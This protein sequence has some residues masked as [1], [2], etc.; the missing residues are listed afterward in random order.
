[1][2]FFIF[3]S[4]SSLSNELHKVS[5]AETCM[6]EKAKS[7]LYFIPKEFD[8]VKLEFKIN[9]KWKY[10]YKEARVQN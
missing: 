3:A 10:K 9:S 7:S 5:Q 4:L 8:I 1:M 2:W 6:T